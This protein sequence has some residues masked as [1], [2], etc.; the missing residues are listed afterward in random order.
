MML[1][2]PAPVR[3]E[4]DWGYSY[5][6]LCWV[7]LRLGHHPECLVILVFRQCFPRLFGHLPGAAY[8]LHLAPLSSTA[9]AVARPLAVTPAAS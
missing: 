1:V 9:S 8:H 2:S 4:R 5:G 3:A 7:V 6:T